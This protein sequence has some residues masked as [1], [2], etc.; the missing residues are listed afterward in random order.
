[1]NDELIE[2]FIIHRSS[3]LPCQCNFVELRGVYKYRR[4]VF[5]AEA[6]WWGYK[7]EGK[8]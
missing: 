4:Q 5:A 7:D 8:N 2:R 3:F 1:M 6:E